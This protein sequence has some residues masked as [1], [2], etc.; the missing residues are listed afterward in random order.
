MSK[1]SRG[2]DGR[3]RN[4]TPQKL[5]RTPFQGERPGRLQAAPLR[6]TAQAV[7]RSALPN[8]TRDVYQPGAAPNTRYKSI[9]YGAL[10]HPTPQSATFNPSTVREQPKPKDTKKV[11]TPEPPP[12]LS[13]RDKDN[14]RCKARPDKLAPRRPG[15]GTSKRYAPWCKK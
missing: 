14:K 15:G 12:S 3:T 1:K 2:N 9:D 6:A 11:F 10:I 8:K 13:A 5:H 7:N 4:G